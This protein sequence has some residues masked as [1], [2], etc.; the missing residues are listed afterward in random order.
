ML[1]E[2][3][4]DEKKAG[5]MLHAWMAGNRTVKDLERDAIVGPAALSY[6]PMWRFVSGERET[7]R[8]WCEPARAS[9]VAVWGD[10]PVSGAALHFVS[11]EDKARLPLEE[12]EVRLESA[13]EWLAAR[14]VARSEV[15]ET[16][17]VHLPLYGFSYT[18]R[19]RPFK[20]AVDA[21]SGR[22]LVG[23][24]PAKSQTAYVGLTA[25][26]LVLFLAIGIASPNVFVRLPVFLLA[27]A[28]L[29]LVALAVVRKI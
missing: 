11:A 21:V 1:A 19:G 9:A 15:R 12:P 8:Q 16:N 22:I 17:L 7:E 25:L 6:F 27:A 26:A 18:W 20:A 24:F 13:F 2:A 29:G 23:A 3:T 14:G 28:P 5:A 4:L 10:V